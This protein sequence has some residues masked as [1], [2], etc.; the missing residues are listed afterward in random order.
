MKFAVI[1]CGKQASKHIAGLK[2]AGIDE[3]VVT[4]VDAE[5]IKRQL[6]IDPSLQ[7]AYKVDEVFEDQNVVG[8]CICTPTPSHGE[9]ILKAVTAGKHYL[10]EKPYCDQID[11]ARELVRMTEESKLV[12]MVGYVYRFV[13]VF[14]IAKNI[15]GDVAKSGRS[16]VLGRVTNATLRLGGRGSHALWKHNKSSGGGAI[17]EM[18]VH[19]IDLAQWYFGE[20]IEVKLLRSELRWPKRNFSG[21]IH[22][23]DAEDLVVASLKFISGI[24]VMIHADFITPSFMQFVEI[25][26]DNGSFFGSIQPELP[27]FVFCVEPRLGYYSGRTVLTPHPLN[28]FD[29]QI[30]DFVYAIQCNSGSLRCSARDALSVMETLS[31]LT[32]SNNAG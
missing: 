20:P 22:Q 7:A 31:L 15:L 24:D 2:S 13:P 29:N 27:S 6:F 28:I 4:D 32:Q 25:Q 14:E 5:K 23:V 19:M 11:I 3:I 30:K 1:G 26:G 16:P 21:E 18:L 9:L 10:C 8:I 12:G 17:N